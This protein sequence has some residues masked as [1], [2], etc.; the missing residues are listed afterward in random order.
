VEKAIDVIHDYIAIHTLQNI[1][2][3]HWQ[4]AWFTRHCDKDVTNGRARFDQMP[5]NIYN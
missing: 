1:N 2:L 3:E 4:R 5:H